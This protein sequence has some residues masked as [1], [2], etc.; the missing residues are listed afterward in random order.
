MSKD[1]LGGHTILVVED[2]PLIALDIARI[3]RAA[4]ANV[5]SAGFAEFG[6]CASE[7]PDLSAAVIDLHLGDGSG[8]AICNRLRKRDVPFVIYTAYPPMLTKAGRRPKHLCHQQAGASGRYRFRTGPR[9]A[10]RRFL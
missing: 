10:L 9:P 4:G 1:A 7:H 3:L 6:L 2:E 8:K 5:L